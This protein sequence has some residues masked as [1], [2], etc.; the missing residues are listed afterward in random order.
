MINGMAAVALL[1][2]VA[3]DVACVLA[4]WQFL[5]WAVL[6]IESVTEDWE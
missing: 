6:A 1:L 5:G 4:V 3:I 2:R